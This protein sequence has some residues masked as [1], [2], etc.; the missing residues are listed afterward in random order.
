MGQAGRIA[1]TVAG[2]IGGTL[3]GQPAIGMAAGSIIG[4][5]LFPASGQHQYVVGPRLSDLQITSGSYGVPI[6]DV[7]GSARIA[8]NVIWTAGIVEHKHV[9]EQEEGKGGTSQTTTEITY[10]YTC[11]FAVGICKGGI[12]SILRIWANGKLIYTASPT[13]TGAASALDFTL[14]SGSATQ[15]VD[16]VMEA[17]EGAG[18]VPAYRDLAYILFEDFD[19]TNYGNALPNLNFEVVKSGTSS[20][21]SVDVEVDSQSNI[22]DCVVTDDGEYGI[23]KS[24]AVSGKLIQKIDLINNIFVGSVNATDAEGE[25]R[26][27]VDEL[28]NAYL[29]TPGDANSNRVARY[30]SSMIFSAESDLPDGAANKH[31]GKSV[32]VDRVSDFVWSTGY[33][34]YGYNQ[35][36]S[37]ALYNKSNLLWRW[38]IHFGGDRAAIMEEAIDPNHKLWVLETSQ[39]QAPFGTWLYRFNPYIEQNDGGGEI[40]ALVDGNS[41]L[42][43]FVYDSNTRYFWVANHAGM[44]T[45]SYEENVGFSLEKAWGFEYDSRYM[46]RIK[47][48]KMWLKKLIDAS[49]YYV[50]I[51]CTQLEETGKSYAQDSWTTPPGDNF[52]NRIHD[53]ISKAF[54]GNRSLNPPRFAKLL[55]DRATSNEVTLSSIVDDVCSQVDLTN[56]ADINTAALTDNV[57]GYV[58]DKQMTARKAIE[59]LQAAFQFDAVESDGK[60]KFVKRGGA[61]VV[62]IPEGDLGTHNEGEEM[63]PRLTQARTEELELPNQMEI[64]Y[65][66]YDTD[67]LQNIQRARR[68]ITESTQTDGAALPIVM[69]ASTAKRIAEILLGNTWVERD[70]YD[71]NIPTKYLYLEPTDVFTVTKDGISYVMRGTKMYTGAFGAIGINAPAEDPASYSSAA[72]GTHGEVTP[73]TEI[74]YPGTTVWAPIDTPLVRDAENYTS[75]LG[76][77]LAATGKRDAWHGAQIFRSKDGGVSYSR[78]APLLESA[79]IGYAATAL[80]DVADPWT[81]DNGSSVTVFL[82]TPD[83]ELDNCTQA[84]ALEGT[85]WFLLGNDAVGW[86]LSAFT[87]A[88]LNADGSYTLSG[89]LRGLR[90]TDWACDQHVSGDLFVLLS[91]STMERI[92]MASGDLGAE[93]IY[94]AVSFGMNF[95]TGSMRAF[96]NIGRGSMPCSPVHIAGSRD[97][98]N[99]LTITW[100]R[101]TRIMGEWQDYVDAPLGEDTESYEIDIYDGATI[102]RTISAVTETTIYT[103]VQQTADG[104]TPGAPVTL[105]AFQLSA[106][107]GRGFPR[108]ATV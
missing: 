27:G 7:Y 9:S 92:D 5:L 4:G 23:V 102:V 56:P 93:Y 38:T 64:T 106:Q 39:Y 63:P 107:I 22:E 73:S 70:N 90:G 72:V 24:S 79:I 78:I 86:E 36:P 37:I 84:Q 34:M 6:L 42:D 96:T 47:N 46:F 59:P 58:R 68:L 43:R 61:S 80:G 52:T 35:R 66:D 62:T 11:S 97:G 51:D 104:L 20:Y 100:M 15:S 71:I 95:E 49:I 57:I 17:H 55:Y 40:T 101:R 1:F 88:V 85:N 25:G 99:D 76:Y 54:W 26:L 45:L 33:Y 91:V 50:E 16:P 48:G 67:Y 14:Y 13:N 53:P 28:G 12:D 32:I 19:L 108:Q 75:P 10:S 81:W 98:A 3:F 31:F 41:D 105:Q 69:S 60:I 94:R 87:T 44:W 83:A 89:L 30:G 8:G 29:H 82:E 77:Y 74:N 21:P 18:N 2:G 103:A 65:I